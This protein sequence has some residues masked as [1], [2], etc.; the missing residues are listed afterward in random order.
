MMERIE[1]VE[2]LIGKELKN[3]GIPELMATLKI[4]FT[5]ELDDLTKADIKVK[6]INLIKRKF[7]TLL[8]KAQTYDELFEIINSIPRTNKKV[9]FEIQELEN[10]KILK[11]NKERMAQLLSVVLKSQIQ[12]RIKTDYLENLKK[13]L[14]LAVRFSFQREKEEQVVEFL[15]LGNITIPPIIGRNKLHYLVAHKDDKYAIKPLAAYLAQIFLANALYEFVLR[16]TELYEYQITKEYLLEYYE[17]REGVLLV[18]QLESA[19]KIVLE[20]INKYFPDLVVKKIIRESNNEDL[21]S[22]AGIQRLKIEDGNITNIDYISL[23]NL[24][25]KDFLLESDY[26]QVKSKKLYENRS[27]YARSFQTKKHINIEHMSV[28]KDNIF[29]QKFNKVELDNIV[30]LYKFRKVEKEFEKLSKEMYIPNLNISFRIKRLGKHK[31]SG[32]YFCK[33]IGSLIVDR[34]GISSFVHELAHMIDY[35]L[36]DIMYSETLAFK[37]VYELYRKNLL[38]LKR[39]SSDSRNFE[40]NNKKLSYYLQKDEVFARSFEIYQCFFNKIE[41]SLLKAKEVYEKRAEYPTQDEEYMRAVKLYF[42]KFFLDKDIQPVTIN[43]GIER[44]V[45]KE[46]SNEVTVEETQPLKIEQL[47]LF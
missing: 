5:E 23:I 18:P 10:Q 42:D 32:I 27:E 35:D 22:L 31:A 12:E 21:E 9:K 47:T 26:I 37:S 15:T 17:D 43:Q 46:K 20:N 3:K 2:K 45:E 29:L 36:D 33:P 25:I 39:Q 4:N 44:K 34:N 7:Q 6:T 13:Y 1:S 38:S 24:M 40:I 19:E 30:D 41:N 28:M 8:K 11:G 16:N 14:P